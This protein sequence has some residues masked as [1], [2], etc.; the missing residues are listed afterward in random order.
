MTDCTKYDCGNR[1]KSCVK[2]F[3]ESFYKP[4]KFPKQ[5][6]SNKRQKES[7]KEPSWKNLEA[8]VA[9]DISN[10]QNY[11]E[12]KRQIQSGAQWFATGDIADRLVHIECKERKGNELESQGTKSFTISKDWLDKAKEEAYNSGKPT[13]LPFRFKGDD[14]VYLVTQWKYI[15][16]VISLAKSSVVE[17]DKKDAIIKALNERITEL[18]KDVKN[19]IE[20]EAEEDI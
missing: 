2:C 6:G 7:K 8:K 12:A 19:Y 5:L 20:D 3:N 18:E 14:E 16:E 4:P 9:K 10:I 1:G 15:A 13:F 17:N 11:Y